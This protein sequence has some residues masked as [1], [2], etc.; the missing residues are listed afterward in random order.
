MV[1][2]RLKMIGLTVLSIALAACGGGGPSDSSTQRGALLEAVTTEQWTAARLKS[3]I[4]AAQSG[5]LLGVPRCDVQLRHIRYRT[6]NPAGRPATAAAALMLP[7]GSDPACRGA[8]SQLLYAH[9][10]SEDKAFDLANTKTSAMGDTLLLMAAFATQGIIVIAP[11]MQGYEGSDQDYHPYLNAEAQAVDMIDALR[12]GKRAVQQESSI[13]L[14][15]QVFLA[16]YSEGGHVALATQR[17]IERDHAAELPLAAVI[18]MS[19]PYNLVGFAD[20]IFGSGPVN[21]GATMFA[22]L[23]INGYQRSYGDIYQQPGDV[24]QPAFASTAAGL[25]PSQTSL[26]ELQ[27]AGRLPSPDERFSRLFGPGGLIN[28][29]FR[30][31][32]PGS[33]LRQAM[34]KNSLLGFTPKAPLTLCG[35]AADPVVFFDVNTAALQVDLSGR[36]IKVPVW[37]IEDRASLPA[38]PGGDRAYGW[39]DQVRT[40]VGGADAF[41]PAYHGVAALACASLAQQYFLS[42]R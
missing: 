25:L 10:T 6:L 34:Q 27:R 22:P 11:N 2:Q 35:G 21:D 18:P 4:D 8:R 16:G 30:Q 38:G 41:R 17:V 40:A 33:K 42:L 31:A 36:G 19:G 28:D 37:N 24:Y 32:F 3:A 12:A 5:E 23:L 14:G 1:L 13:S 39:F 9:G 20:Q 15:S 7:Q 29:S 26:A